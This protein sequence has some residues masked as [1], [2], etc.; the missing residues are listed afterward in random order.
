MVIVSYVHLQVKGPIFVEP[1]D[2]A[3]HKVIN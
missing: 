3:T 1:V 2:K